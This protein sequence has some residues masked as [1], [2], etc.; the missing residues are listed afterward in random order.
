MYVC[1]QKL[2]TRSRKIML[3]YEKF[4]DKSKLLSLSERFE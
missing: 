1:T 4:E 3:N 2:L